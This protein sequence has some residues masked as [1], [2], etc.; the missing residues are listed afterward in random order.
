LQAGT[1]FVNNYFAGDPD[2]PFGGWK[3][4]GWGRDLGPECLEQ[5]TETKSVIVK[6]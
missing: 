1:V 6:L 4:S 2:L 3:E 5:Y